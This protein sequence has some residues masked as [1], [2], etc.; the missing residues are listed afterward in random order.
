MVNALMAPL[1]V[2]V[3]L[4]VPVPVSVVLAAKVLMLN[5]HKIARM[6]MPDNALLILVLMFE[7]LL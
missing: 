1:T 6:I 2:T 4:T 7:N 3:P 5:T